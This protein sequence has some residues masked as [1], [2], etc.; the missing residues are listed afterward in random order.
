MIGRSR[1]HDV[2]SAPG[3]RTVRRAGPL[4]TSGQPK[5]LHEKSPRDL[6]PQAPVIFTFRGHRVQCGVSMHLS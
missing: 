2:A 3:D 6:C 4:W 1:S 5:C